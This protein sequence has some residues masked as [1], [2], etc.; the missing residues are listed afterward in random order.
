MWRTRW[1]LV[2]LGV[3][4]SVALVLSGAVVIGAIVGVMA[5]VRAALIVQWQRRPPWRAQRFGGQSLN[6]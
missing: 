4:L 6:R 2:G 1:L 3:V 5:V